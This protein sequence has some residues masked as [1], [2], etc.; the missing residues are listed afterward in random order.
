[1]AAGKHSQYAD[2]D[3]VFDVTTDA[4]HLTHGMFVAGANTTIDWGD[5]TVTTAVATI[6]A[7][8]TAAQE[9]VHTYAAPGT[10]TVII[11]GQDYW[12]SHSAQAGYFPA[13]A[14]RLIT[15]L[16]QIGSWLRSG[17]NM[18]TQNLGLTVLDPG[19]KVQMVTSHVL[20]SMFQ[21][22]GI[23]SLNDDFTID[24]SITNINYMF[25]YAN[26]LSGLPPS[27]RF[28]AN[29]QY[30]QYFC[31]LLGGGALT[32]LPSALKL[33]AGV[34]NI[35][36]IFNGA[37][38]LE[39]DISNFFPDEW[40]TGTRSINAE[41]IFNG[42]TKITG[43]APASLLWASSNNFT[44]TTDAFTGCTLLT[45]WE[46]IPDTWGGPL[47]VPVD[48]SRG[49]FVKEGATTVSSAMTMTGATISSGQSQYVYDRGYS[50]SG[51]YYGRL[52]ISS[53][54][55]IVDCILSSGAIG[56]V[57]SSGVASGTIIYGNAEL[58]VSAGGCAVSTIN[59][60]S[61]NI[62]S[63]GS[64]RVVE[65]QGILRL[66]GG[67]F[68][69]DVYVVNSTANVQMIMF[70]GTALRASAGYRG[71]V[72]VLSGAIALSATASGGGLVNLRGGSAY[73][74][75]LKRYGSMY[76]SNGGVVSDIVIESQGFL[77]VSSGG[78]A[79]AVT[80]NAGATV[81]VL[82][83]GYIEYA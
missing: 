9:Q 46:D 58:G 41:R 74:A 48:G 12:L 6:P 63:G 72:V 77:T 54:G 40:A 35:A 71:G 50:V 64:A 45:N 33:P 62:S 19:C 29:L 68:A 15:R 76:I 32:S 11:H 27:F 43:T 39:F 73:S 8:M 22:T 59:N 16:R 79:L 70:G 1:M 55:S 60:G 67:G 44:N 21:Q 31:S 42:C 75:T 52:Y 57:R 36:R 37:S 38:K 47:P 83:D 26:S 2:T 82:E 23:T 51:T 13:G 17:Q 30:A 20:T 25:Y 78:T 4:D 7:A 56:G 49:V 14:T 18:F 53:G 81:T 10:Y 24:D 61:L 69:E 66:Y 80:S 65:M 34:T 5:G 3:T 28:P